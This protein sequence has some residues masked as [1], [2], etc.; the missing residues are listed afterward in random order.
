[1]VR[2]IR[3]C[4]E[5]GIRTVAVYSDADASARHVRDADEAVRIGG[6]TPAESYLNRDA[7]LDA[8]VRT[9]CE[10]VHPGYG[11]L[12]EDAAFARACAA[13]GVTFI[14]P[15][16]A[17]IEAMGSKISARRLAQAAGVPVV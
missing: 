12:A 6:A 7:M 3:T 5:M 16:A 15:P 17:A 13:A 11:F 2:I 4:R 14:G 9:G 8:A 1:A 10:A